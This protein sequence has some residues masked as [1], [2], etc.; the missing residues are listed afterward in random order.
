[1]PTL[2]SAV[3][4]NILKTLS[5]QQSAFGYSLSD[6][7]IIGHSLGSHAAGE[8]GRR[9][10]GTIGRITG[11]SKQYKLPNETSVARVGGNLVWPYLFPQETGSHIF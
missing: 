2:K 6:V 3:F 11:W 7:H 1:M 9:T 8:A 4:E 5:F 10:N